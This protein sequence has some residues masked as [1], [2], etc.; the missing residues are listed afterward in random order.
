M[1]RYKLPTGLL[2]ITANPLVALFF[3]TEFAIGE[4][5]NQDR[6]FI[7]YAI[8]IDYIKYYDSD[9]VS[10]VANIARRPSNKLNIQHLNK[11]ASQNEE[12]LA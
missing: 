4:E 1:Q 8:P 6:D 12:E 7:I 3:A 10:A 5:E 11:N 9:T 2:D